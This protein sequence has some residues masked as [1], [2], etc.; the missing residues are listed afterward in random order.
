VIT[1]WFTLAVDDA[2]VL[3]NAGSQLRRSPDDGQYEIYVQSDQADGLMS[4]LAQGQQVLEESELPQGTVS[5]LRTDTEPFAKF[6]VEKGDDV[7]IN[8]NEVTAGT[9]TLAVRFLDVVDLMTEQ[10]YSLPEIGELVAEDV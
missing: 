8:Y 6:L 9:G 5:Q 10:G 3:S 2:D 1:Q 4:V 7:L